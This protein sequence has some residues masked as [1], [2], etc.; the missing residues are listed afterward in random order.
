MEDT[1]TT[2]I[3]PSEVRAIMESAKLSVGIC[4]RKYI[5]KT[6]FKHF[7]TNEDIQDMI[8]DT[9]YRASRSFASYDKR[10]GNLPA[11]V[12]RIARNVFSDALDYKMK[13]RNISCE[14][15]GEN[16]E[17]GEEFSFDEVR[18]NYNGS[19][20][21]AWLSLSADSA[22]KELLYNEFEASLSDLG[23]G[24]NERNRQFLKWLEEGYDASDMSDMDGCSPNAASKRLWSIRN[25]IRENGA[26]LFPEEF[27][28]FGFKSAC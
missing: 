25:A 2:T 12:Y 3:S 14:L 15:I 27:G 4:V 11:W 6:G 24:K 28:A 23:A 21:E 16:S 10:K 8:Q 18:C 20:C 1:T 9:S 26:E 17:S 22:D 19:Y 5:G 13:R 7:F